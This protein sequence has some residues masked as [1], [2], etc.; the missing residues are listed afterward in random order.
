MPEPLLAR[1]VLEA[2]NVVTVVHKCNV[3][4]N[5]MSLSSFLL[6]KSIVKDSENVGHRGSGIYS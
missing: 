4:H 3:F 2:L 5:N 1:L 6:A